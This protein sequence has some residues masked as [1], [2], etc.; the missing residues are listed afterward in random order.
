[1]TVDTNKIN[2]KVL[3]IGIDGFRSDAMQEAITPFM[4]N[5]SLKSTTYYNKKKGEDDTMSGPKLILMPI[6]LQKTASLML[7]Y[8][9]RQKMHSST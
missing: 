6:M 3:I 2:R 5:L 8:F 7:R 1:M 9:S 4:H